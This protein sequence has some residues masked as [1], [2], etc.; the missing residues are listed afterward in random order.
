MT[1]FS[2]EFFPPRTDKGRENLAA[3][4][5]RLA[6]HKP[7]YFS[8]TFGAGGSTLE[9]TF[10]TVKAISQETGSAA[11][12]HISCISATK[13]G[14]NQLLNRYRAIGIQR[15]V[16]LRG[17]IP[18]GMYSPGEFRYANELVSFIRAEHGDHF[19]ISVAAYPEVHPQARTATDDL[20]NFLR[21]VDAGADA[22]ITQ[23]FF[24]ADG[25][26]DFLNRVRKAGVTIPMV[27]GIMPITNYAQLAR[28]SDAC[29]AEIPRW[30]R[31]QLAALENENV[32]AM[33]ELGHRV[34]VELCQRLIAGGVDE[35]HFYTLNKAGPCQGIIAE[36]S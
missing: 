24:N 14:V 10:D 3:T 32:E 23:Y 31:L 33:G 29:G 6:E 13:D 17:D 4:W 21:K 15:L 19:H 2:F 1:Q 20:E 30:L 5:H 28:F 22:A 18:S 25:Y 26:F 35:L 7:E 36:L 8:V 34:I 11:T 16:V 27:P 12:P 9:G